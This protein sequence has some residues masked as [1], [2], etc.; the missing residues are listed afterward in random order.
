MHDPDLARELA[1]LAERLHR[2]AD[3]EHT[4]EAVVAYACDQLGADHGGISLIRRGGRLE[5]VAPTDQVVVKADGLQYELREGP[6]HDSAW[7]G[8]TLVAQDLA[9]DPRWPHWGPVAVDIGLRSALGVELLDRE[10][11]RRIGAV[12]LYWDHARVFTS[13]EIDLAHL[14]ARHA[15]L[16]LASSLTVEGLRFAMDGRKRIGQAQGILME[17]HGLD[18]D[19]AFNVLK[20]YSQ[21]QNVKLRDLAD[22]LVRTMELPGQG[23]EHQPE[24]LAGHRREHL[25][26]PA[27]LGG[28]PPAARPRRPGDDQVSGSVSDSV[29]GPVSDQRAGADEREHHEQQRQQAEA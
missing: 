29:S 19:Q 23:P 5:T 15:A 11:H 10:G 14:V 17:R 4:A 26:G 12:N 3:P 16:A 8:Q 27:P 22:E 18:E 9:A 28:G 21:D 7:E 20:R 1:R 6:C 25:P 13:D 24:H 2:A